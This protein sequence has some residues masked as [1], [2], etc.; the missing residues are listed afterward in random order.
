MLPLNP[1]RRT[2]ILSLF[3]LVLIPPATIA[4]AEDAAVKVEQTSA[5]NG[6]SIFEDGQLIAGYL[7]DSNGKP[8]I[9]PL[10]SVDGRRVVRDFPMLKGSETERSDHDHHRSLWL[11]HGDVNGIDFWLDDKGC[12][13]IVQTN[14]EASV[15][16]DGAAVIETTNDWV[17]PD[18][19]RLLSDARRFEF[20]TLNGRRV[21]DCDF[22]LKA[23][24]GDVN[25]GDTKEGSFGIRIAGTMKVDAKQGGKI[26][27]AE[28]L[29]NKEAWGKKSN[30]VNYTGPIDGRP[31]GITIHD[32]PSSFQH[33]CRWHVRTY[34][35]FAANPFGVHHFVGG[36]KTDGV[37]LKSGESMKLSY[38][39]V[40]D[41]TEFDADQ[42]AADW[43]S[44]S[45]T[46]RPKL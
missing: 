14:G 18:G 12:G 1:S 44:Y 26:T 41:D 27:N 39:V 8:I 24:D 19:K 35:L 6:W 4:S 9:Y 38:R 43:E 23:T 29:N 36:K 13:K 32:H 11:T 25:F 34:G 37:V 45:K 10:Q 7:V 46:V 31:A 3:C 16:D 42:T 30:W 15:T 40:I 20:R 21:I 33:P 5:P 17:S 28:G 2:V 22:L